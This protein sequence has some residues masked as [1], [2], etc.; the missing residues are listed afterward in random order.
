[1]VEPESPF[2]RRRRIVRLR[3][4]LRP[5]EKQ[6]EMVFTDTWNVVRTY[7]N[8]KGERFNLLMQKSPSSTRKRFIFQLR[9]I[10]RD[11]QYSVAHAQMD[12]DKETNTIWLSR[13]RKV[14]QWIGS[15]NIPLQRGTG[16]FPQIINVAIQLGKR[17]NIKKIQLSVDGTDLLKYYEKYGFQVVKSG[18]YPVMELVIN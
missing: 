11:K 2:S 9:K 8:G 3:R 13:G 15:N 6:T 14:N 7:H 12:I 17:F 1:M 16:F 5:S 10:T 4:R 18:Q